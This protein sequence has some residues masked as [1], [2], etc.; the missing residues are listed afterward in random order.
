MDKIAETLGP[1]P[2]LQMFFGM[3]VLG[4]GVYALVRGMSAS[5]VN[6]RLSLEDARQ[7]WEAYQQLTQIE[8]HTES[9]AE[10]QKV[11]LDR[12][13]Q[14]TEAVRTLVVALNQLRDVLWNRSV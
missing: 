2:I 6:D 11:M 13:N 12:I 5:K 10:N 9:I 14:C 3:A 4:V 8:H 1:W 7:E